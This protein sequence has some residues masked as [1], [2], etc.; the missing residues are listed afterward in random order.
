MTI[1]RRRQIGR[2]VAHQLQQIRDA[3]ALAQSRRSNPA[4][5]F[6]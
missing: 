3:A 2:L 6:D 1:G 5:P 4:M